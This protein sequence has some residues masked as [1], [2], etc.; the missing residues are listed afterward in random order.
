MVSPSRPSVLPVPCREEHYAYFATQL[1]K[2]LKT[3]PPPVPVP[4]PPAARTTQSGLVPRPSSNSNAPLGVAGAGD[5]GAGAAGGVRPI[6]PLNHQPT[7]AGHKSA[8]GVP[9]SYFPAVPAA[10][11]NV[12]DLSP[13]QAQIMTYGSPSGMGPGADGMGGYGG[14]MGGVAMDPAALTKLTATLASLS[15][16]LGAVSELQR[17]LA[18]V[19]GALAAAVSSQASGLQSM[20][21]GGG[22][23]GRWWVLDG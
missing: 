8:S 5:Y 10:G 21:V 16:Q 18:E 9:G 6:S 3:A 4:V 11:S 14:A 19:K 20:Q 12:L 13:S 22:A 1:T 17:E 7:M 2:R 23:V 15:A